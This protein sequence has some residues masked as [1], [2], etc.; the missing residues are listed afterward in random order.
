MNN[1]LVTVLM[2]V[3]NAEKYVGQTIESI[4]NQT[5]RHFEFLIIDDGST[6]KSLEIINSYSD[7]RIRVVRNDK[8]IKLISTLNKG[9]D[10]AAGKYIC[11]ADADDVNLPGRLEKQVAFMERNPEYSA[12]GSWVKIFYEDS[13]FTFVYKLTEKHDDIRVKTLYQNHFCH[14]AS[15]FRKEFINQHKLRFDPLFIH[16][17]DYCFFVRL[18]EI[19]KLYN[20][21]E[22]L[23]NIR[24][25]STNVSVLNADVQ[26]RNSLLVIKFQLERMGINPEAINY[27]I[28]FRLFYAT[29]D[30]NPDEIEYTEKMICDFI[31]ANNKN[32]YLPKE[33]FNSFL[34]DK[35][36]HLCMNSTRYGLWIYNKFSASPLKKYYNITTFDRLKLRIKSRMKYRNK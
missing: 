2:P 15:F 23:V 18:S 31:E 27:D 13:D 14:P 11:R 17:E 24:K 29:F 9:I 6:D 7:N 32:A 19:G 16:S 36:F 10:L 28:Y 33:K 35:W 20:I 3:Y 12:C 30:M 26:N 5:Y 22:N 4:L 21:Q 25:H 34:S 1:P 8:N